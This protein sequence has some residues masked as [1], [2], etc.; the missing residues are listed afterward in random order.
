MPRKPAA[1]KPYAEGT[2]V[3]VEKS[4]MEVEKL[5]QRYGATTFAR[6]WQGNHA[7]IGFEIHDRKM[8]ILLPLPTQEE[9]RYDSLARR[10]TNKQVGEAHAH[11]TRRRWRALLLVIKAQLEAV[12]SG[13]LTIE[14]AM[15]PWIVLPT[16][17]TMGQWAAPQIARLYD[18]G[19]MPALLPGLP[20][21][22]ER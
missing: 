14:E 16:G 13:I 18:Q 9:F 12:A 21:A 22:E 11:E 19:Q 17:E 4:Q 8:R 3:E 10:Q 1:P 2:K 5:L 15:M 7:V 20:P 6:G